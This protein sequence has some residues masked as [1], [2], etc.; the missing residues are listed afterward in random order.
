MDLATADGR[1][2]ALG[3]RGRLVDLAAAGAGVAHQLAAELPP[4]PLV[5][6]LDA[7][8]GGWV[9]A[10]GRCGPLGALIH[11]RRSQCARLGYCAEVRGMRQQTP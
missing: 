11:G 4:G 10:L 8:A 9:A 1:A 6:A 7:G 2:A 5:L 3:R